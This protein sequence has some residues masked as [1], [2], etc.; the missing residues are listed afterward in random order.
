MQEIYQKTM[1]KVFGA[2]MT[3]T[4]R[5]VIG[6]ELWA[7]G[8]RVIAGKLRKPLV[9]RLSTTVNPNSEEAKLN[10][11]DLR[12]ARQKIARIMKKHTKVPRAYHTKLQP[13]E[14]IY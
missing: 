4:E 7:Q 12:K 13:G 9:P 2:N 6:E 3:R 10:R 5:E 11:T 14:V 8:F 1:E